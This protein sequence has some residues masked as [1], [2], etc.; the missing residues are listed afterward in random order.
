MRGASGRVET[1]Y[2]YR[3]DNQLASVEERSRLGV[4]MTRFAYDAL[5]R[6]TEKVFTVS[7]IHSGAW[8]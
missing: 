1:L 3:A 2:H 8:L 6:R 7:V 5:G 4:N